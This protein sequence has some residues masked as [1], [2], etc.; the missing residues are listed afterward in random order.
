[1]IHR[2]KE[3]NEP[4]PDLI[5]PKWDLLKERLLEEKHE[6]KVKSEC[7]R[8]TT[9]EPLIEIYKNKC[10]VCERERGTE[11][12]VDHYRPK[13]PRLRGE[14]KYRQSGYFW[15]AFCLS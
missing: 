14:M 3:F 10:A 11:L 15:L 7:Y 13:K 2:K 6:H 9:I 4:P 1:M 12:Q 5:H 8:D